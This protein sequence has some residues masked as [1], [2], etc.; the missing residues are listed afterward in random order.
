MKYLVFL[1]I[2]LIN[3]GANSSSNTD[4]I[5]YMIGSIKQMPLESRDVVNRISK[6]ISIK[7]GFHIFMNVVDVIP[8]EFQNKSNTDF[9]NRRDYEKSIINTLP[10]PYAIIFFYYQDHKIS[11]ISSEDFSNTNKLLEDYAFP[12]LPNERIGSDKYDEGINKGLSNIYLAVVK[13]VSDFYKIDINAPTPLEQPSGVLKGI[14]YFMLF[15]MLG[16]YVLVRFGILK[17]K[18][19]G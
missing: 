2:F 17:G 8:G 1:A 9:A 4:T 5:D 7:S 10:K 13:K 3:L 11:L 19:N 16:L 18:N 14:I 15:S 12:Y 6:E